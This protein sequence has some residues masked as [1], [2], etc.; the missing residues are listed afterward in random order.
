MISEEMSVSEMVPA[1][2]KSP[3]NIEI[4]RES[5]VTQRNYSGKEAGEQRGISAETDMG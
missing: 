4:A 2:K 5:W 3:E 1:H